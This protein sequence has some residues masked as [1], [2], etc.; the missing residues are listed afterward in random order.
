MTTSPP[1]SAAAAAGAEAAARRPILAAGAL[2]AGSA[3]ALGAFGAH[4]LRHVLDAERL[5]WW[6]TAVQ[7]Q[8]WHGLALVALAAAP[9]DRVKAPAW[10]L[11]AGASLFAISLYAMALS[12]WRWLGA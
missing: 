10:L 7:Y 4:G 5:G 1:S 11:G 12:G 8:A 2:L 9:V 6:Q 3:V